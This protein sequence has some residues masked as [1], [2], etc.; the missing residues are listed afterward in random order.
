MVAKRDPERKG[1]RQARSR[2]ANFQL[3]AVPAT[4]P[5][6]ELEPIRQTK[7]EAQE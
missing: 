3:A 7:R 1:K 6:K 2:G 4:L 5:M